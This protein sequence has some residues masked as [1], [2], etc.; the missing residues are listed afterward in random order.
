MS[1]VPDNRYQQYLHDND[2]AK[3]LTFLL[4]GGENKEWTPAEAAD[5]FAEKYLPDLK[6]NSVRFPAEWL[7][8]GCSI[9]TPDLPPDQIEQQMYQTVE[10]G[11]KN[12]VGS[13]MGN[14]TGEYAE[15]TIYKFLTGTHATSR[16]ALLCNYTVKKFRLFTG[17]PKQNQVEDSQEFDFILILPCKKFVHIEVKNGKGGGGDW[18]GQLSK[19]EEFYT[20]VLGVLAA[21]GIDMINWEFVPVAAFPNAKIQSKVVTLY[22]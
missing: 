6:D 13:F 9:Q 1:S 3:K 14:K 5:W 17:Q 19:G 16:T 12:A 11:E 7:Y 8:S 10:D 4:G 22:T 21:A 20:E 15:H 18:I 2:Q